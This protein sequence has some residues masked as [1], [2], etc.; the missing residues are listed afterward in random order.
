MNHIDDIPVDLI[1][2]LD[3][4]NIDLGNIGISLLA[5]NAQAPSIMFVGSVPT[6]GGTSTIK[7]VRKFPCTLTCSKI[8]SFFIY[9]KWF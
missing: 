4:C 2:L 6:N 9:C 7:T 5:T 8:S 3:V 1:T